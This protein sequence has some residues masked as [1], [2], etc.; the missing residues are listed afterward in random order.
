MTNSTTR[1]DVLIGGLTAAALP[2]PS[3]A[4]D[5]REAFAAAPDISIP[6]AQL[7][8]T[9]IKIE[10]YDAKGALQAGTGYIY[11][12]ADSAEKNV[13]AIVADRQILKNAA[14]NF[15]ATNIYLMI[16]FPARDGA[17]LGRKTLHI[18]VAGSAAPQLGA[19]EIGAE[20]AIVAIA[21]W[22]RVGD[23]WHLQVA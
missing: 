18:D 14:R 2:L 21:D 7:V 22:R 13:M 19:G 6:M 3:A 10:A 15:E 8:R 16:D 23:D 17:P 11:G 1:R 20:L 4:R 12:F 9:E 5:L